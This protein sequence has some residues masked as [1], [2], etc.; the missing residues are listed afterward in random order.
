MS[1]A[2]PLPLLSKYRFTGKAAKNA[3]VNDSTRLIQNIPFN[4]PAFKAPGIVTMTMVSTISI[5]VIERVSAAMTTVS[6]VQNLA[7]PLTSGKVESENPN[8]KA[9]T[10]ASKVV[11]SVLQLNAVPMIRPNISPIAQPLRQCSVALTA[12][13]FTLLVS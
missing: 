10:I 4:K 7:P 1:K 11:S 13:L 8:I 2:C 9:R 12:I 3:A 6:A 5:V